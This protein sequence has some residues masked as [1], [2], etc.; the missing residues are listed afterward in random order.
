MPR[1]WWG[2]SRSTWEAPEVARPLAVSL[3]NLCAVH[4]FEEAAD[5]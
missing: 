1:G 2:G 3:I 5:P 4:G